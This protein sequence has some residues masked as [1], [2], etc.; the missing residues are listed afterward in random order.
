MRREDGAGTVLAVSLM[1]V[2]LLVAVGTTGAVG[3]VA[4]HRRAQSGADL[5]ALAAAAALQDGG[6]PCARARQIAGR[7]GTEVRGCVVEGWEVAVMVVAT[8]QRILGQV[9]DLPARAR[10]GPVT[11][12]PP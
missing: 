7:N 2:V 11:A 8:S 1:G 3:L 12:V 10:A 6:D 5:A 4:T 9:L